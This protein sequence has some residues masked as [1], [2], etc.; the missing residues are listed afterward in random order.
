MVTVVEVPARYTLLPRPSEGD[1]DDSFKRKEK[2]GGY[3][4][5]DRE[6]R[7]ELREVVTESTFG[8]V[9]SGGLQIALQTS[10]RVANGV[11]HEM[12]S[13]QYDMSAAKDV[14]R[15]YKQKNPDVVEAAY[16]KEMLTLQRRMHEC[17]HTYRTAEVP[18]C[19]RPA[20][21][22]TISEGLREA[23]ANAYGEH[24][25]RD[26][27]RLKT[28]F[29]TQLVALQAEVVDSFVGRACALLERA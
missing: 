15:R 7:A 16:R 28:S 19:E 14:Y 5:L 4:T 18:V 10:G 3:N 12:R 2:S 27:V 26:L 20:A 6:Q 9:L 13:I 24:S 11:R 22:C 29:E 8:L 23:F 21:L 1:D 25:T 17:L